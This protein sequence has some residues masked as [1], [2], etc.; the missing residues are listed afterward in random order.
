MLFVM[1]LKMKSGWDDE[2]DDRPGP[3][4]RPPG[5]LRPPMPGQFQPNQGMPQRPPVCVILDTFLMNFDNFF[6]NLTVGRITTVH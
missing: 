1:K 5:P 2:R 4:R 3:D 6:T